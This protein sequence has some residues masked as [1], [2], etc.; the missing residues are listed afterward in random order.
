[1]G[2][3]ES[4][5][6]AFHRGR[7]LLLAVQCTSND[8]LEPVQFMQNRRSSS[9]RL[10]QTKICPAPQPQWQTGPERSLKE[11]VLPKTVISPLSLCL[12]LT[13]HLPIWNQQC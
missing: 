13:C 1:M 10:L 6:Q 11:S 2:R 5:V 9:Y 8:L 12:V 4:V 3:Y 7:G